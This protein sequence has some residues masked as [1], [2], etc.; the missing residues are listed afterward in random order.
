MKCKVLVKKRDCRIICTI[1]CDVK[2]NSCLHL[3]HFTISQC[4]DD[5]HPEQAKALPYPISKVK[6]QFGHVSIR[7]DEVFMF[8]SLF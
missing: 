2:G 5:G 8:T 6:L 3:G 7:F 4:M 1:Y